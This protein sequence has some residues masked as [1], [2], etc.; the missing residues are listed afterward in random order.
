MLTVCY[1]TRLAES[2]KRCS[3]PAARE[4]SCLGKSLN[5][6]ELNRSYDVLYPIIGTDEQYPGRASLYVDGNVVLY[7]VEQLLQKV[8]VASFSRLGFGRTLMS[9]S[10]LLHVIGVT[11][12]PLFLTIVTLRPIRRVLGELL[13]VIL[14][15]ALAL[16][17][18]AT[19]NDL[20][21][22]IAGRREEVSTIRAA[23]MRHV[24]QSHSL[25][26]RAAT[27]RGGVG[28]DKSA[29]APWSVE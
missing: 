22:V 13:T 18:A 1:T 2:P 24:H 25:L 26:R 8:R 9:C 5:K 4:P 6:N 7:H 10:I 15:T 20:V 14:R 19:A 12:T 27:M 16:A 21:W 3:L 23:G 28:Q 29:Q 17:S 11:L